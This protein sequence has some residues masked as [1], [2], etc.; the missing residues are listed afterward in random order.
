M[1]HFK[2]LLDYRSTYS[3]FS[4]QHNNRMNYI[5][6]NLDGV[7]ITCET[8]FGAT[9]YIIEGE[10]TQ[11]AFNALCALWENDLIEFEEV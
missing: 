2:I 9:T 5:I 4:E 6:H 11:P 8:D 10:A 3:G 1:K 7:K